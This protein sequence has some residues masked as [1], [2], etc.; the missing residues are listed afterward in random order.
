MR[1]HL[2][3]KKIKKNNHQPDAEFITQDFEKYGGEAF[4]FGCQLHQRPVVIILSSDP[5]IG[6]AFG[7]P[8][9]SRLHSKEEYVA[10]RDLLINSTERTLLCHFSDGATLYLPSVNGRIGLG[11]RKAVNSKLRVVKLNGKNYPVHRLIYMAAH[12]K[13]PKKVVHVNA[14]LDNEGA[15]SNNIR[16]LQEAAE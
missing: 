3:R 11:T 10:F 2:P 6:P 5:P 8:G 14:P 7:L 9:C 13:V 1:I 4:S 15:Y 12:N 16:Y